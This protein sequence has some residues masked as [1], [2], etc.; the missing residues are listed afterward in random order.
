[1]LTEEDKAVLM[2]LV[3]RYVRL[4]DENSAEKKLKD[5]IN[6]RIAANTAQFTK[7][8]S[9]LS[10]FDFDPLLDGFKRLRA[11]VGNER[12][13]EAVRKARTAYVGVSK[14]ALERKNN[15]SDVVDE[16]TLPQGVEGSTVR[17]LVL[18]RLKAAGD[19][20]SKAKLIRAY[21]ETARSIKLHEKTVGMTLY[22]LGLDGLA[23]RDGRTWFFVPPVAETKNPGGE[24][25][26]RETSQ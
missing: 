21:I 5:E 3:T 10:I 1:M 18:D 8:N 22:R 13:D 7:L 20:G 16:P 24:T 23:R 4:Y 2:A 25:P 6:A 17:E 14:P 26:G 12:Y 9:A 15:S 19:E 11:E